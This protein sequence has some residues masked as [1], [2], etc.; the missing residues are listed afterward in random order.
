MDNFGD[1]FVRSGAGVQSALLQKVVLI[2]YL[3]FLI[4]KSLAYRRPA[5]RAVKIGLQVMPDIS[6]GYMGTIFNSLQKYRAYA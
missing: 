2:F 6:S 1:Q 5:E 4:A 3:R